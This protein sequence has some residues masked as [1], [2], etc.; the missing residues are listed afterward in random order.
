MTPVA[1]QGSANL[2]G[3]PAMQI[4]VSLWSAKSAL[5]IPAILRR[6]IGS[7]VASEAD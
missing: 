5:K 7:V 4:G 2:P 1:S 6:I 3:M